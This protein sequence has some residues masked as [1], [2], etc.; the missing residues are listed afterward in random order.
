MCVCVRGGGGTRRA[1]RNREKEISRKVHR[2]EGSD[3]GKKGGEAGRRAARFAGNGGDVTSGN[4]ARRARTQETGRTLSRTCNRRKK[5]NN[6]E[7]RTR[8][9]KNRERASEPALANRRTHSAKITNGRWSAPVATFTC[10]VDRALS[11][12][13]YVTLYTGPFRRYLS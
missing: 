12:S 6:N 4:A 7:D 2:D 5:S 1:Q 9:R 8:K 3:E 10:S 13:I 11:A